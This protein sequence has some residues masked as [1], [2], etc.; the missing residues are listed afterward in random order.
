MS[1]ITKLKDEWEGNY[2]L[3]YV[4]LLFIYH[5]ILVFSL[6]AIKSIFNI[7]CARAVE[8]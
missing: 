6:H 7:V 8:I 5:I 1:S 2:I 4:I 3:L